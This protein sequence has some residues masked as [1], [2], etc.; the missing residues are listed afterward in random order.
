M[1]GTDLEED[2]AARI[3]HAYKGGSVLSSLSRMSPHW[4]RLR[5]ARLPRIG[6]TH[7]GAIQAGIL[8]PLDVAALIKS[9]PEGIRHIGKALARAYAGLGAR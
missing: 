6:L 1:L 7:P 9:K 3:V 4:M 8:R 2:D 5:L